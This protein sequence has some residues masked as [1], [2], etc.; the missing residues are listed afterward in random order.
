MIKNIIFDM[1]G[2]LINTEPIHFRIWQQI[3]SEHGVTLEYERY[4]ACIGSTVKY[5]H[6]LLKEWYGLSFHNNP[7]IMR[8]FRECKEEILQKEGLP[9]IEGAAETVKWLYDQGYT[10]AVASSSSQNYIDYSIHAL[11]LDQYFHKLISGESVKHPK[12]A[13]DVFLKAAQQLGAD[14]KE[15]LVIED[16]KN[17]SIAAKAAGMSCYGFYNPDSGNQDLSA[18]DFIFYSYDELKAKL[19][20]LP[21]F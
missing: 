3:C 12:P 2:V 6:D 14:P 15:C 20:A 18:A 4:I 11:G 7:E 19:T 5:L 17:G 8:R 9:A 10:M 21:P 1:D 16:S 13:P